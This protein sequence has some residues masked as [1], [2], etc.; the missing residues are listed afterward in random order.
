M[1]LP[2]R[3]KKSEHILH[4]HAQKKTSFAQQFLIL[5]SKVKHEGECRRQQRISLLL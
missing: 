4:R 5:I 1:Q 3:S 2:H